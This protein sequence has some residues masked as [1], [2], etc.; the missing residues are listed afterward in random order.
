MSH[1]KTSVRQR[2]INL[3][4]LVFIAMLAIN[5]S[6]EVLSAFGFLKD[7]LEAYNSATSIKNKSLYANLDSKVSDQF[8]KYRPL[9]IKLNKVKEISAD[10]YGY[11][12]DLKKTL[13]A[14]VKD[15]SNYE[16]MNS[17]NFLDDY[18]F[19]G[20]GYSKKG[21]EFIDEMNNFQLSLT[22]ALGQEYS[23]LATVIEKRFSAADQVNS[24]NKTIK[25]LVYHYR[26]FPLIASITNITQLQTKIKNTESDILNALL[27]RKLDNEVSLKNYKGIVR[28]D[29]SAYFSGENVT[30]QIVLGRYDATLLPNKVLLNDVDITKNVKD[31][32]VIID[33]P[34]GNVGNHDINGVISFVQDG[35]PTDVPF[36]SVY[37]VITQPTEAVISA[38]KMNV[39]YRGLEN[40]I[41][42]S[43]PGVA[44]KDILVSSKGLKKVGTG[45]YIIN[46]GAENELSVNVSA[47]LSSGKKVTSKKLFRVKDVPEATTMIRGE[48]GV[49]SL[50][51]SSVLGL[52]IDAGLPDFVFDLNLEVTGFKLKVPGQLAI[53]VSG[54]VMD[55]RSKSLIRRA[56]KGDIINIFE[57][58]AKI[59]GKS[60]YQL[61]KVSP[62]SVEIIN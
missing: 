6:P 32:Q 51:K 28:L 20:E 31:G 2:M 22:T 9:Q 15:S 25:W 34:A 57:V 49:I 33:I 48:S 46:P 60:S 35:V 17:S 61:K 18:F 26:G 12:A 14:S 42:V 50:P 44:D 53:F 29:K 27:G 54:N 4:Y 62:I 16:L 21:Q 39:V 13:L 59:L 40:P 52:R 41:S 1:Q 5:L 47:V 37:S 58:K 7:D 30:G 43:L 8:E 56:K 24:E 36:S 19:R 55:E 23:G 11:L 38:D 45:K 10:Y 3:M